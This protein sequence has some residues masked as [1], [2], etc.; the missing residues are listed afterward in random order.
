MSGSG[1]SLA[2][3]LFFLI[4]L[5]ATTMG[6]ISGIGGGVIIKP[7]LDATS[8]LGVSTISF[9]SGCTVLS[10]AVVSLLRSRGS[11]VKIDP[12]RSTSLAVGAA[13]GGVVGKLLFDALKNASGAD[14]LVG[15]AQSILLLLTTFGVFLYILLKRRI[16][17]RHIKNIAACVSIGV[18]LGLLSAFLGIGGGPIN[19]AV[20]SYFL[21]MDSKTSALNSI[22]IILFSQ[23]ASFI[24]TLV[25]GSV[26]PFEPTTLA[27]MILGGVLGGFAGRSFSRRMSNKN[28]DTLFCVMLFAIV[29]ISG[30]NF[31]QFIT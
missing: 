4:S 24:S 5:A 1:I 29:I 17:P 19:I 2:T 28:V 10:M 15:S 20:L 30:Y 14:A 27:A 21:A 26:P 6:A 18:M 16:P 9:L 31:I 12:R 7:V 3:V 25:T 23:S 22:Y 13:V 11:G 8:G